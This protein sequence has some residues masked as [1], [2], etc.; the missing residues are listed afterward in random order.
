MAKKKQ[1]KKKSILRLLNNKTIY[2]AMAELDQLCKQGYGNCK[3][4]IDL[5]TTKRF[6]IHY[7]SKI[8][9]VLLVP[10]EQIDA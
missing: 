4:K 9:C 5:L 10:E 3:I 1:Y 8:N 2:Q 6:G 7:P